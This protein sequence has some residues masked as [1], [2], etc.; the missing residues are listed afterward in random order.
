MKLGEHIPCGYSISTIWV[1]DRI[2][3]K[4]TLYCGKD[5]TKKFCKSLR[6]HVKN[7][8]DFQKKKMLPLTEEELKT[9]KDAKN[10][11]ICGKR[12]LNS[13]LNV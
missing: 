12:I 1:F 5:C 2:E 7:I 13:S 6:E 4:R 8:I 10:Y 9:H 3:N 11:Y